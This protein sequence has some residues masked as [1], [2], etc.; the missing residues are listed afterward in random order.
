MKKI[1]GFIMMLP[2][3]IIGFYFLIYLP[4]QFVLYNFFNIGKNDFN[5][6][7]LGGITFFAE[8]IVIIGTLF[9]VG[10]DFIRK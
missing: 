3:I 7:I 9:L 1:L 10:K 8:I 2:T 6:A 5:V 4:I